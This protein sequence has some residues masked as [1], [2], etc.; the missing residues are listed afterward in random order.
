MG[1]LFG[2]MVVARCSPN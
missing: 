1:T 2:S